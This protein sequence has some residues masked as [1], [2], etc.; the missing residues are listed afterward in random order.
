MRSSHKSA[1]R[2]R[3]TFTGFSFLAKVTNDRA[4]RLGQNKGQKVELAFL[5]SKLLVKYVLELSFYK[6]ILK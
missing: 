5:F 1:T 4:L 6:K 2:T 3:R